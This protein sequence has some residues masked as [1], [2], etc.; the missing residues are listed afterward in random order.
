MND[1]ADR[2]KTL[3]DAFSASIQGGLVY[4]H[5]FEKAYKLL[6]SINGINDHTKWREVQAFLE[7]FEVIQSPTYGDI[8]VPK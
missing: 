6:K 7:K 4:K 1:L 2:V 5:R 8:V 3:E